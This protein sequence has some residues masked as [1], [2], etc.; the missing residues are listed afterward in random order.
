[1]W[2]KLDFDLTFKSNILDRYLGPCETQKCYFKTIIN[3]I[4]ILQNVSMSQN[5]NMQNQ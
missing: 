4:L 3:F 2:S 5:P 1:M